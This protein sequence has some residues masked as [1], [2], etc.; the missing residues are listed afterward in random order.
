MAKN[1]VL[2]SE[3]EIDQLRKFLLSKSKERAKDHLV[4]PLFAKLFSGKFKKE[5]DAAGADI[6]IEG[7]LVVELKSGS[8][9]YISGL[10]QALHYEKKGLSFSSVCVIAHQ[11]IGLWKIKDIPKDALELAR[12]SD[13]L[14]A[15]NEIGKTNAHK[16]NRI[17]KKQINESQ[18]FSLVHS[19]LE[20]FFSDGSVI[21]LNEFV[22]VLKNLESDRIQIAPQNFI[23]KIDLLREFFDTPLDAIHCFY[24]IVGYWNATS[25]VIENDETGNIYVQDYIKNKISEPLDIKPKYR[26]GFRKFVERHYVFTNEGSG[27][28]VDYYF[29]R[30]DEVITKLDP[31]YAIQH[32]I[33][34]TDHNLSKFA[35]WFVHT[36][37]ENKLSDKYIVL[38]PAGGS[39][40]LVTSWR[41][42]LK[43]KI[44]SELQP[45]LLRTIERRMRLDSEEVQAGF[46]I[47]P[48][49]AKNEGLNF[50]DKSAEEYVS[51]LIFELD[52]KG[53]KL[54]KPIAFL[55]NPPYKNTD[56]NVN[57]RA[58]VEAEYEI[59]KSIIDITGNDAAKERYLAFLGQILNISKLQMGQLDR[60]DLDFNNFIVP[61]PLDTTKVETPLLLIFTPTSWLLPRPTYEPFRLEFDNYFKYETGFIVLG[62][63]FFKIKGRFPISFTIWS[64]NYNPKRNKN[65]IKIRDLTFLSKEDLNINWASKLGDI[66]NEIKYFINKSNLVLYDNSRGDI[67]STLPDLIRKEVLVK[68]P[69]LNL[70]RNRTVDESDK[71][72]ISGFPLKDERHF[73]RKDPHG[74]TNGIYIG[75]MD[76][77]TPLRIYQ[78]PSNRISNYPDRVWFRLDHMMINLNQTRC[79]SGPPDKYGFCA[80]DLPSAIS[81]FIWFAITKA[82]NGRYPIWANQFDIWKPKINPELE[83]EFYSLCFVFGLSENRCVVT[84]FEVNNPVVDAPE[85]FVDNPLCPTNPESFWSTTLNDQ[86]IRRPALA[87]NLV[88]LV[89][90]LYTDWNKKYCK[91]K[92]LKNIGLHD[93]A[94]FKY[95][96]YEDFLTPYS[97][98]I[99]IKKYAEV[100]SDLNLMHRFDEISSVTKDVKERIYYLLVDEFKYFE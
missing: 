77:N 86:I 60:T 28:T 20:G 90:E 59:N 33:F 66:N 61:K 39:G 76:D 40:N 58:K 81:T 43:H 54:D 62:N 91:N 82:I 38:D 26:A 19:D 6:Y 41:G 4:F 100:N 8:E 70:Y 36:Y 49:T 89:R 78:E 64:Y 21:K 79:L 44:V 84:K 95:F 12:K 37:Y 11:F 47:I 97:G 71:S 80:Y 29:S 53:L 99:Q 67:R 3:T 5:S 85:V 52:E 16:T 98:L 88:E 73:K 34:F 22:S 27:L 18:Y 75:F 1:K 17:L 92:V 32:G 94:Y 10:Y 83:K 30:F 72:I 50:L 14:K 24:A 7:K 65:R 23:N 13:P 15:P 9:D 63:E 74:Y 56:E 87:N 93:E 2:Q 96:D 68:Q 42:H 55:L 25:K 45:D 57:R 48:K 69:R 31:E 46:T 51:K 35:L